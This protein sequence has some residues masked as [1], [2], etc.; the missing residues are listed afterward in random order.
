MMHRK[1]EKTPPRKIH[2]KEKAGY[3]TL[4]NTHSYNS[5]HA[6]NTLSMQREILQTDC[7]KHF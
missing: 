7:F 5:Q 3:V 6:P 4:H 1:R 2:V